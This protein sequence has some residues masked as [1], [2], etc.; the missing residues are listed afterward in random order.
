MYYALWTRY[1][2]KNNTCRSTDTTVIHRYIAD[3]KDQLSQ[4]IVEHSLLN[5]WEKEPSWLYMNYVYCLQE[6]N[7]SKY[8]YE[9]E[10]NKYL[11]LCN[12]EKRKFT[13]DDDSSNCMLLE[14]T[15]ELYSDIPDLSGEDLEEVQERANHD[16]AS[17]I[18]KLAL[19]K[20]Y[21]KTIIDVKSIH[22]SD[23]LQA[24]YQCY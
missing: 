9:E 2:P 22:D 19:D 17:A 24:L 23:M 13:I 15:P 8:C 18:D 20:F 4:Y 10:F 12:Y 14:P 11:E 7:A 1:T 21:F 6:Q 16:M 5:S 3:K